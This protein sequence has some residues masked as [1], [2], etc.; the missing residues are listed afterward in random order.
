[1]IY[2]T[3]NSTPELKGLHK[4]EQRCLFKESCNQGRRSMGAGF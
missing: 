2:W 4:K 3:I 1:M